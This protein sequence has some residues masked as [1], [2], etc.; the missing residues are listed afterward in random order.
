MT[1]TC[2]LGTWRASDDTVLHIAV[3]ECLA[4]NRN[5]EPSVDLYK[6][7]ID[8]YNKGMADMK[9]RAPGNTTIKSVAA[10]SQHR[11]NG[12]KIPFNS[13]Y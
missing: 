9:D 2:F 10:L 8:Y 3:A 6:K 5:V 13:R 11:E 1:F 4:D 12:H 7:L